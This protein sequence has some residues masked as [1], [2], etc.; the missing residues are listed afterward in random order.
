[1]SLSERFSE[2]L[3][4]ELHPNGSENASERLFFCILAKTGGVFYNQGER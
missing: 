4:R 2:A 1:M 3:N